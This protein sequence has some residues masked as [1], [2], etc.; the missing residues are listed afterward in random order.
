M[1]RFHNET[2]TIEERIGELEVRTEV[3]TQALAW[4]GKRIENME[5]DKRYMKYCENAQYVCNWS[6]II[7]K[8]VN[9]HDV[10][11]KNIMAKY[12]AVLTK[13]IKHKS[14]SRITMTTNAIA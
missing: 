9:R 12:C 10:N 1:D 6:P 4:R 11:I 8:G 5:R 3:D 7:Q 13:D 2:D 14:N